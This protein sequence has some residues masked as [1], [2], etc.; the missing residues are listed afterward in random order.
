MNITARL[1]A[2]ATIGLATSTLFAAVAQ[3]AAQGL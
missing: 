2:L 3:I 1:F